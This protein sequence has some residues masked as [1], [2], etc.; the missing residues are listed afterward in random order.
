MNNMAMIAAVGKNRE[1]GRN[2]QLIWKFHADMKFFR[3]HTINKDIVMG[4]KTFD[5][6]P[7]VLPKR[8]HIILTHNDL[9]IPGVIVF[10]K[11]EEV[12]KY[13]DSLDHDIMIIGGESIYK[14]FID[15]VDKMY[16]TEIDD[17]CKEADVFFPKFNKDEWYQN[18]I[19]NNEEDN[20]KFK[21][22]EYIRKRS[23]TK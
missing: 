15:N 22:V 12:L 13:A 23:L 10:H 8:K 16:L 19:G 17:V 21:H 20:I 18:V 6:L 3:E 7:G 9:Y 2:N 14:L 1:L 11:K 4:R 5:S